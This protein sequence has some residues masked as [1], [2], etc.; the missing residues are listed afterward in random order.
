MFRQLQKLTSLVLIFFPL[1]LQAGT[2]LTFCYDPYPPYT[3]GKEGEAEGGTKVALLNAVVQR[4]KGLDAKVEILPWKRC[5][6]MAGSGDVDGILPLFQ[7][8]NALPTLRSAMPPSSKGTASGFCRSGFRMAC[9]ERAA[10]LLR[11][12]GFAWVC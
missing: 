4:I 5:Q 11:W 7:T 10:I 6:A 2:E 9:L 8:K 3:L 1:A 12:Q